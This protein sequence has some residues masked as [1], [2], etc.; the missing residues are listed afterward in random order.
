MSSPAKVAD[1]N[2]RVLRREQAEEGEALLARLHF[3]RDDA[4]WRIVREI[5]RLI[6]RMDA[7]RPSGETTPEDDRRAALAALKDALDDLSADALGDLRDLRD[8]AGRWEV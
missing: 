4:H 7:L 1:H 6:E 2:A 5:D 8:S 3:E